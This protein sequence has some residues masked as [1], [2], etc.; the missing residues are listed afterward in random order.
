M[1]TFCAAYAV[2]VQQWLSDWGRGIEPLQVGMVQG[3]ICNDPLSIIY[4]RKI[5]RS[6]LMISCRHL[7]H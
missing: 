4:A 7:F 3:E 1:C 5:N 2:T 6:Y